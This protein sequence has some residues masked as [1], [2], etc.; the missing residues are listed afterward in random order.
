[1]LTQ[2]SQ[3]RKC[4]LKS[5]SE[6]YIQYRIGWSDQRTGSR[7]KRAEQF[8]WSGSRIFWR[9]KVLVIK[10]QWIFKISCVIRC[11]IVLLVVITLSVIL[12]NV[13]VLQ[14]QLRRRISL[15]QKLIFSYFQ[16]GW[17][18]QLVGFQLGWIFRSRWNQRYSDTFPLVFPDS[19]L[20]SWQ[21]CWSVVM[22]YFSAECH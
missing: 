17:K 8:K 14:K 3:V 19:R 5:K 21:L 20:L 18:I 2:R 16:P 6:V 12:L 7:I 10:D 13:V 22:F 1:M 15:T 9:Q 11:S 4:L